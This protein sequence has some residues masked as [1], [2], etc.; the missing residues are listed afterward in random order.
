[1]KSHNK[2]AQYSFE[3]LFN[4]RIGLCSMSHYDSCFEITSPPFWAFHLSIKVPTSC[5]ISTMKRIWS[6]ELSRI[7]ANCAWMKGI[8]RYARAMQNMHA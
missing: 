4:F 8:I 1:M 3:G 6:Q 7:N 2:E 5:R